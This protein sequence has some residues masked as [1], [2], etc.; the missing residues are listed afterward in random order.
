[1][2]G[3]LEKCVSEEQY[4]FIEGRYVLDNVL[5]AIEVIH[6]LKRKTRGMKGELALKIDISRVGYT[7]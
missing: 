6:A 7:V 5:I 2:K 1:L 4:A 3:C